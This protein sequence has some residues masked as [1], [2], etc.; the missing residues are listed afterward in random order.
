MRD[1]L[2]R[3]VLVACGRLLRVH[4]AGAALGCA[5]SKGALGRC[6]LNGYGGAEDKKR[7]LALGR[8]SAAAG[9]MWL[10]CATTLLV[11][12]FRRTMPRLRDSSV[13]QQSRAIQ[14]LSV[15]WASCFIAAKVLRRTE[16]RPSDGAAL[17]QSRGM[18]TPKK[19][20][21]LEA[22]GCLMR[23]RRSAQLASRASQS[24]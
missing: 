21:R 24:R 11:A 14:P 4:A 6:Y 9:S 17:Q 18:Q 7:G 13:L 16:Q 1:Q 10:Q 15:T 8:E 19:L 20:Y 5:H 22:I 12:A 2:T 23:A 3:P